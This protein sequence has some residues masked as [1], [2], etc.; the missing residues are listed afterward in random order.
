MTKESYLEMCELL[1]TEPVES[2]IPIE[3]E[4]LYD[5]VQEAITVYNMLQDNWDTM[6]GL[7][8]GKILNGI[9]DIFSIAEIEDRQTCYKIIQLL[10]SSRS[11]VIN[12]KKP[13]K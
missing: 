9:V 12:E 3:F 6:N 8:L 11:K 4:D 10:D 2:E 7:Y 1:G 13:A 5:E